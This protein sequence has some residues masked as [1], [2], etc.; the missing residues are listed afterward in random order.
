MKSPEKIA[1]KVLNKIHIIVGEYIKHKTKDRIQECFYDTLTSVKSL[2]EI[3]AILLS[4][5]LI[6]TETSEI[7]TKWIN[8]YELWLIEDTTPAVDAPE[9]IT[10]DA[11]KS[12]LKTRNRLGDLEQ[13]TSDFNELWSELKVTQ[14]DVKDYIFYKS[15]RGGIQ[16]VFYIS[17]D[18]KYNSYYNNYFGYCL[19]DKWRTKYNFTFEELRIITSN[20]INIKLGKAMVKADNISGVNLVQLQN[21]NDVLNTHLSKQVNAPNAPLEAA[22]SAASSATNMDII[23]A[24]TQ[25][26]RKDIGGDDLK[27]MPSLYTLYK[28]DHFDDPYAVLIY[29]MTGKFKL[30]R[31]NNILLDQGFIDK[32]QRD[33]NFIAINNFISKDIYDCEG[34]ITKLFQENKGNVITDDCNKMLEVLYIKDVI[35]MEAYKRF[36]WALKAKKPFYYINNMIELFNTAHGN[37][38]IKDIEIAYGNKADKKIF[39]YNPFSNDFILSL[40]NGDKEVFKAYGDSKFD[41]QTINSLLLRN[42]IIDSDLQWIN[43][44]MFDS[45]ADAIL[46][47]S[48]SN[49]GIVSEIKEVISEP[50]NN[51]NDV[52][53]VDPLEAV[54]PLR[55]KI[56]NRFT[57]MEYE[58]D[59]EIK[60]EIVSTVTNMEEYDYLISSLTY[61]NLS[62]QVYFIYRIHSALITQP[63]FDAKKTK[64]LQSGVITD[65]G[66]IIEELQKRGAPVSIQLLKALRGMI[67]SNVPGFGQASYLLI[68][69]YLVKRVDSSLI[70]EYEKEYGRMVIDGN[71][72]LNK[73]VEV[74]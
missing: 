30:H 74:L 19:W 32:E 2:R 59:D 9:K 52:P 46:D 45:I 15:A 62:Q 28:A 70:V 21:I 51:P 13:I 43:G 42:K 8:K 6:S 57:K 12:V 36:F 66:K 54:R 34:E 29:N 24:M 56:A 64:L 7:Y 17:Q 41:L 3:T 65:N 58:F 38:E 23:N 10:N 44:I 69:Y 22:S 67:G 61:T 33:D 47:G 26:F 14:P 27:N 49:A 11:I 60:A 16:W 31:M 68:Y 53:T 37:G 25:I 48:L 35:N 55:K 72:L 50:E 71:E 5:E 40:I 39:D 73:V 4:K 20:F 18:N 1:K 63:W